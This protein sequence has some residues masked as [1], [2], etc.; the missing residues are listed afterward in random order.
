M[1][2]FTIKMMKKYIKLM[3]ISLIVFNSCSIRQDS[4]TYSGEYRGKQVTFLFVNSKEGIITI[5]NKDTIPFKYKIEK[6]RFDRSKVYPINEN[7]KTKKVAF[8]VYRF[9]IDAGFYNE[10]NLY[11]LGFYEIGKKKGMKLYLNDG[12][13]FVK[14]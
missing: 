11:P 3:F 12:T 14:Q 5:D 9:T 4:I 1:D 2:L 8:Y 13:F 7:S 10:I 6:Y